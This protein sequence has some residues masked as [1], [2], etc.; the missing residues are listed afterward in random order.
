[1]TPSCSLISRYTSQQAIRSSSCRQSATQGHHKRT[2]SITVIRSDPAYLSI[3]HESKGVGDV[4][5]VSHDLLGEHISEIDLSPL[6]EPYHPASH[7]PI[8]RKKGVCQLVLLKSVVDVSQ[9]SSFTLGMDL[10]STHVI[11]MKGTFW[12]PR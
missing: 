2:G 4:A 5:F 1:M 8:E 9:Y 12:L 11:L 10:W 3:N 7:S 6:K